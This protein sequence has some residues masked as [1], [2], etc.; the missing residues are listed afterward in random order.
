METFANAGKLTR[1]PCYLLNKERQVSKIKTDE[2]DV[3]LRRFIREFNRIPHAY[4]LQCCWGHFLRGYPKNPVIQDEL[5]ERTGHEKVVYQIAYL[6]FCV[7]N[8]APGKRLLE[9]MEQTVALDPN[10][11]Q[12]GS[13]RWFRQQQVNSYV[14]QVVPERFKFCDRCSLEY[15][16]AR[17]IQK[18][19]KAFFND[20]NQKIVWD[21]QQTVKDRKTLVQRRQATAG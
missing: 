16:E 7:Q 10:F 8:C 6:A 9:K 18:L 17:K 4:T 15:K 5:P 2:I 21:L 12:F 20:M 19:K 14:L 11:V 13:A 3:P 1:D